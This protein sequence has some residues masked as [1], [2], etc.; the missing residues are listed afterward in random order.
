MWSCHQRKDVSQIVFVCSQSNS[1]VLVHIYLSMYS[2]RQTFECHAS[3][4]KCH[5]L[6]C[7]LENLHSGI[8]QT[9]T[10]TTLRLLKSLKRST[11]PTPFLT[12]RLNVRSMMNM[13]PWAFTLLTSSE[14]IALNTTSSCQ[15]VGSR[16]AA[17]H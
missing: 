3:Q 6:M 8:I 2:C 14:K 7:F 1:P 4:Q 5:Y 10:Q 13:D 12:M 15:N 11:T 16:C 17:E 9:R